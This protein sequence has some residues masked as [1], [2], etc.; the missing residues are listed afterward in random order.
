MRKPWFL[1]LIL[2]ALVG[3]ACGGDDGG[4]EEADSADTTEAEDSTTTTEED[5][6]EGDGG[7]EIASVSFLRTAA[8]KT[9]AAGSGRMELVIELAGMEGVDGPVELTGTGSYDTEAQLSE[10]TIDMS[11]LFDSL[12]TGGEADERAQFEQLFGDGTFQ[13]ITE[14]TKVYMNMP[15]LAS[16]FGS[17]AEWISMQAKSAGGAGLPG[18]GSVGTGSP[19]AMLESLRGVSD[20]IVEVGTEDVRGVATTHLSGTLNM[21]RAIEDA[22]E[23]QREQVEA[24]LSQLGGAGDEIPYEVFVDD[25]GLV[26]RFVMDLF[27]VAGAGEVAEGA[28]GMVS[29]DFFDFGTAVDIAAPPPEDVFDATEQ[30]GSLKGG[31]VSASG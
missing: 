18:V 6:D 11:S 19:A 2:L 3:A 7:D 20:D 9:T 31:G 28:T 5:E 12:G 29:I 4:A 24:A 23:A 17:D 15:F 14:G 10:M 21:Q 16:L 30:M 1:L 25:D 8:E 27:A 13:V 26:R 22:P